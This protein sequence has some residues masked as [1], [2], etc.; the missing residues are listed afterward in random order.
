MSGEPG[1][2]T[3]PAEN[4]ERRGSAAA[5]GR[6]GVSRGATLLARLVSLIGAVVAVIIIIGIL[7]FVLEAN[8]RNGIVQVFND[9]TKWLVGPFDKLFELK[10]PKVENAV[11]WGIAAVVW[12]AIAALIARV[13]RRI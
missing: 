7:L 9:V 11:N 5:R 4:R 2:E 6:A 13:L 1:T 3:R 12:F 10:K 8:R